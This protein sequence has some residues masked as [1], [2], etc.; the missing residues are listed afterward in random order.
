M[1][2]L[3]QTTIPFT[4]DDWNITRFHLLHASL[5]QRGF[6]VT[7]RDKD[8]P[9]ERLD[10]TDFDQMWL[11]AVDTGTGLSASECAA[12]TRFR[13]SGRG[14]LIARDH[15]DLGSSVCTIGGV[16]DANFFHS[17]NL[18]PDPSRRQRDDQQAT[19]IDWPN[20]HSGQNGDYQRIRPS[21]DRHPLLARED[22]S[23][24]EWF[25]AHP[26]EGGVGAPPSDP[27]ARVIAQGSSTVTHRVFN[28]VVAFEGTSKAGRAVAESSFHHFCDYNWNP[29][30]GCPSF[31]QDPAGDEVLRDPER[32]RDV[33]RYVG[34]VAT[35]LGG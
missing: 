9:L 21:G 11:I 33:R 7:S 14:L 23:T 1:K 25:P 13:E 12:I 19:D 15:Q 31:V 3:L 34:N 8:R 4:P 28:L 26:H 6:D 24:I 10:E 22:G 20:F 29:L 17:R 2:I 32:L 18:D 35:W 30:A 5:E 16:G 27:T